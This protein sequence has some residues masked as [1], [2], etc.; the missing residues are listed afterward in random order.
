M[1]IVNFLFRSTQPFDEIDLS[2]RILFLCLPNHQWANNFHEYRHVSF[3]AVVVFMLKITVIKSW[4][5]AAQELFP[6]SDT[7]IPITEAPKLSGVPYVCRKLFIINAIIWIIFG[8]KTSQLNG[9]GK[10]EER[11]WSPLLRCV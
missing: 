9:V 5:G 3:S 10:E 8:I 4:V 11:N 7:A 6:I 1:F 2:T